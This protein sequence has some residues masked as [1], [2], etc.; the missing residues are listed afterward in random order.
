MAGLAGGGLALAMLLLF[1]DWPPFTH[2]PWSGTSMLTVHLVL[3]LVAVVVAV[4]IV[5][6]SWHAFDAASASMRPWLI[7]GFSAVAGCDLVHALTYDGMPS[8]LVPASTARAIFFW[9]MGRSLEVTTLALVA[10][11]VPTRASRGAALAAGAASIVAITWFGSFAIDVF[12]IT[13]VRGIGVTDFKADFEYLLCAANVCVAALLWRRA[14]IH[15]EAPYYLLAVSSFVMGVGELT[16][17]RYV[18]PSDFQNIFGH[19][20]KVAAYVLLYRA[21][22]VTSMRAPYEDLRASERRVGERGQQLASIVDSTADAIITLDAH[23]GIVVFNRAAEAMFGL[24][25]GKAAETSLD[26]LLPDASPRK[27]DSLSQAPVD[28]PDLRD[29][30]RWT[31]RKADGTLFE[32]EIAWSKVGEGAGQ[33][34]TALVRDITAELMVQAARKAQLE[35]EAASRAKSMF[36]ANMSHEIRTPMNAILGFTELALRADI[37]D[38]PRD[39]LARSKIAAQSL[40]ELIEQILD[41]SKIEARK[42]ELDPRPFELDELATRVDAVTGHFARA[43]GLSFEFSV[44]EDVPRRLVGDLGRLVQVVTNL[45]ANAVKFTPTGGVTVRVALESRVAT[46]A[47][48]R[49]SVRDTGIGMNAEQLARVFEPFMQAEASISGQYGGT[50]LGLTIARELVELMG[51]R[52]AAK[53]APGRGSEFMFTVRLG[54]VAGGVASSPGVAPAVLPSDDHSAALEGRRVLLVEDNEVNRMVAI[55]MLREFAGVQ[56]VVAEDGPR[57]LVLADTTAVDLVLLDVQLPTM[58]GYEVARRLRESPRLR[59]LPI[60][61]LTAHATE[62]VRAACI[63]AGM[64]DYLTKPFEPDHLIATMRRW[65]APEPE[66][67]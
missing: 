48:L 30:T 66:W 7:A 33:L 26:T 22:F 52:I 31:A 43:K 55:E 61:A 45:C 47:M 28:H 35:A 20:F 58:D 64:N 21:V 24:D 16:F 38:R 36:L 67:R 8:L 34:M 27:L 50:G 62:E 59:T 19:L 56:V 32:V 17:T 2:W 1:L 18:S 6:V 40:L 25:A 60:V 14:R 29:R 37:G 23:L 11:R 51:G 65:L 12:P 54:Q 46:E 10:L 9:L 44:E 15:H 42:L 57:A 5:V 41:L 39:F 4:L 63:A 49:I 13:F 53:S 3:E